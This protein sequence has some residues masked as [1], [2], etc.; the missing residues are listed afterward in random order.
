MAA[1]GCSY[2]TPLDEREEGRDYPLTGFRGMPRSSGSGVLLA[3]TLFD[4]AG[5]AGLSRVR[6]PG[7]IEPVAIEGLVH[8]GAGELE[9]LQHLDGDAL[10][11]ALQ[12]R[13]LLLGLRARASTRPRRTLTVERVLVGEGELAD[14]IL[15]GLHYDEGSGGF[16]LSFCTATD[17]TQL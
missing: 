12:H 2:G 14:G 4:D 1:A 13:R 7:E 3:T 8:E 9:D 5:R 6:R 11:G 17:P 10:R 15:H 16:A